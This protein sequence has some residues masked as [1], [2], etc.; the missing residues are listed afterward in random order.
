MCSTRPTS[1]TAPRRYRAALRGRRIV[2][3]GK[4][5]LTTAVARWAP[6][7]GL[8]LD[9][10]SAGR[11]GRR[12]G[13]RGG[14]GAASSCTA[15]RRRPRNCAPP[16]MRASGASSSTAAPRS[17]CSPAGAGARSRCSIRV[18]PGHRHPRPPRGHHRDHRPEVRLR[19]RRRPGRRRRRTRVLDQPML[20]LVGLHCHLGSQVTDP[21]LYGEAIRRMVAADGRHPRTARRRPARTEHRRRPRRCPTSRGDAELDLDELAAVIDDALDEACAAEHFPGR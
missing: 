20:D 17:P 11:A 15:T 4:A 5:L 13:R 12:A 18:T 1:A 21:A 9:V 16:P 14:P 2:Y 8:G 3:A 6:E 7:E 19:D 10:C